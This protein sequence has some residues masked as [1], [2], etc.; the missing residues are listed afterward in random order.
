MISRDFSCDVAERAE[1]ECAGLFEL[2]V[3]KKG[4]D[5]KVEKRRRTRLKTM[6]EIY[7][8]RDVATPC[9]FSLV[10]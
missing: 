8:Q 7:C 5:V 2:A 10:F 6:S 9:R 3:E 4:S 1:K